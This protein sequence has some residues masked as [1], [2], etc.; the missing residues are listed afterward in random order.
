[1]KLIGV[2][3][4]L[5]PSRLQFIAMTEEHGIGANHVVEM[6]HS[7]LSHGASN[8]S[9]PPTLFIQIDHCTKEYNNRYL[10]SYVESHVAW[11]V[12][13][14]VE[15]SCLPIGHTPEGID[16]AFSQISQYLKNSRALRLSAL[17]AALKKSYSGDG[18]FVDMKHVANWSGLCEVKRCSE[19]SDR[20]LCIGFFRL[21][22]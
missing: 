12:F 1:M 7:F 13:Q 14:A 22:L 9:L 17:H 2:L 21:V 5:E 3:E 8:S 19:L 18:R 11:R 10:S 6:L 15:G 20:F 16:K 4:H